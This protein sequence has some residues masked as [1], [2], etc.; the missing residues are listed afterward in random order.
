MIELWDFGDPW[1]VVRDAVIWVGTGGGSWP[2]GNEDLY[3]VLAAGWR[4][5]GEELGEA[6]GQAQGSAGVLG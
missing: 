5:L 1:N 3:R 2:K 6:V 4:A